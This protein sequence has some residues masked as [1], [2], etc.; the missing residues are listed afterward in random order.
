VLPAPHHSASA[1]ALA[2]HRVLF[3]DELP[4]FARAALE[5][6]REPME[7]GRIVISRA[8]RQAEFPA[9]FQ[10]LA[11]MNPCPRGQLGNPAKAWRCTPDAVLR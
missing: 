9:R 8:A 5:A 7:T 10:F 2:H 4:E 3:L 1:A 6:L 11:A